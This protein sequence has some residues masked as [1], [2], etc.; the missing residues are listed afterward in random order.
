[1]ATSRYVIELLSGIIKSRHIKSKEELD[2]E[3]FQHL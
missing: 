2:A 1:M 3:D